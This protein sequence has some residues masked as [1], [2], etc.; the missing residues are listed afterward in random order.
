V[1]GPEGAEIEVEAVGDDVIENDDVYYRLVRR[2]FAVWQVDA[3][4]RCDAATVAAG[5]DGVAD[6]VAR[7]MQKLEVE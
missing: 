7:V 1:E 6:G 5:A 2:T 4:V 3:A